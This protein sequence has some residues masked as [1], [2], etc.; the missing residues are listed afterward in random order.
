MRKYFPHISKILLTSIIIFGVSGLV[1][2]QITHASPENPNEPCRYQTI[3]GERVAINAPCQSLFTESGEFNSQAVG[4]SSAAIRA[5]EWVLEKLATVILTLASYLSGLAGIILNGVLFY[6]VVNVADN[7]EKIESISTTWKVVRDIANMGFIFVLLYAAINTIIGTGQDNKKLIVNVVVIAILIN[8]S[9]FFTR[10]VIDISN[11]MALTF[12][13]A[14]APGSLSAE[15]WAG[16]K[17]LSDAFMQ[18]LNLQTLYKAGDNL[19][20]SS[21]ITIGVLGTIMLLVAAFSFFAVALL[22][23]IRYVVLILVLVL[24]P[25]AFIAYILPSGTGIEKYRKQWVDALLGQSFFAPIYFMLTWVALNILSGVMSSFEG[26]GSAATAN[27]T[28]G[29]SGLTSAVVDGTINSGAFIMLINFIIVIVLIIASLI[30]AKSWADKAGGGMSKLTSWATGAAG[31]MTLGMAGRFGRGTFGRAGN[32]LAESEGLKNAASKGGIAGM[33]A[34][35]ALATSRKTAG[36]SFDVRGT[37]LAS[38]LDAGKAQKGGF[39]KDLEEKIKAQKKYAESFKP[40]DLVV[41]QAERELD[42][43]K[44][45]GTIADVHAAQVKV[46]KLKGASEEDMR[47]RKIKELRAEDKSKKQARAEVDRLEDVRL[48]RI[49]QLRREE[50]MT[51]DAAKK[52]A[53]EE[54]GWAPEKV[55]GAGIERKES[56]AKVQEEQTTAIPFT[57]KKAP[58]SFTGGRLLAFVGPVKRER[59]EEAVAIRKSIKEKKPAEKIAEEI[60][61]QSES[62]ADAS[63]GP[64]E[65]ETPSTPSSSPSPSPSSP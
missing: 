10:I 47:N 20:F 17:G 29:L 34:R 13:D 41:A 60:K 22:F 57:K 3:N 23:I 65:P 38:N 9:L 37:G 40:S 36:A 56:Y 48:R 28:S 7:Y 11:V 1:L 4:E 53:E 43:A 44:K 2:P 42:N 15:N 14:I 27:S 8:F 12:Y 24:S 31:G 45:T 59:L 21:I 32:A 64:A 35:L 62:A 63:T 19:G 49:N 54:G 33:G 39:T 16:Q 30:V 61:N 18:H 46:D 6:T 52:K 51:E 5:A 58:I 50:N 26:E 55:K 25:I